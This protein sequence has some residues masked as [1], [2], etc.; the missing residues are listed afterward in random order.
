M[1]NGAVA[2][3]Y[4]AGLK[5]QYAVKILPDFSGIQFLALN[6]TVAVAAGLPVPLIKSF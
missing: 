2:N 4:Y 3:L 6:L 1:K 5:A